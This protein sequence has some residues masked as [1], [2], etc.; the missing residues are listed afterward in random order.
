MHIQHAEPS[1]NRPLFFER[2]EVVVQDFD[3]TGPMLD[4]GG[5]GEGII[6]RLKGGQS[7]PLTPTEPNWKK[8]PTGRTRRQTCHVVWRTCWNK[9]EP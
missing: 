8:H 4:V 2:Q 6:G 9:G 3:S 5:R 7:S 1:E